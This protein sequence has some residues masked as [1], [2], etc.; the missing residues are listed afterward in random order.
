[1]NKKIIKKIERLEFNARCLL[2]DAASLK[3][4]LSGGSDSSILNNVLSVEHRDSILKNRRKTAF[5]TRID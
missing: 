1:M 4:E 2:E 3:E 5:K